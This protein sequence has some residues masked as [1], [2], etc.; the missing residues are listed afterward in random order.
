VNVFLSGPSVVESFERLD[1]RR[2]G[3]QRVELKQILTLETGGAWSNHPATRMWAGSLG[4]VARMG[5]TCCLVWRSRGYKDSL[6]PWFTRKAEEYSRDSAPEWLVKARET[7]D[8]DFFADVRANLV[9]KDPCYNGFWPNTQPKEGYR[10]P[11][12]KS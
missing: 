5:I 11:S 2:L 10:W 8:C 9:R 12:S 3:K 4:F 1:Y 6:L 7:G